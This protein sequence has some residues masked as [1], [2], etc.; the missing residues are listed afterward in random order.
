MAHAPQR[1]F[2]NWFLDKCKIHSKNFVSQNDGLDRKLNRKWFSEFGKVPMELVISS[3][4]LTASSIEF[5]WNMAVASM[6]LPHSLSLSLSLSLSFRFGVS[7]CFFRCTKRWGKTNGNQL[8]MAL[9]SC[10]WGHET[11]STRHPI[12]TLALHE[13]NMA[14]S[15][16]LSNSLSLYRTLP[17]FH[18]HVWFVCCSTSSSSVRVTLFPDIFLVTLTMQSSALPT[19]VCHCFRRYRSLQTRCTQ[20][21][22]L[23]R[24]ISILTMFEVSRVASHHEHVSASIPFPLS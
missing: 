7:A 17:L 8:P 4:R 9:P 6:C 1:P 15:N 23:L 10:I 5:Y 21:A 22:L 14:T 20:T 16:N 11:V 2:T 19:G 3:L 13:T 24:I 18:L 12:P